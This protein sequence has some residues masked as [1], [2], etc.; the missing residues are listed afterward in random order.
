MIIAKNMMNGAHESNYRTSIG[1]SYYATFLDAREK[2]QIVHG[3]FD[4]ERPGDIHQA[5]I[6]KLKEIGL[7]GLSDKLANLKRNRG[8][9]DYDLN[10]TV[11][12]KLADE[13]YQLA[14]N[15][16]TNMERGV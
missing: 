7:G 4:T 3:R 11:D 14:V 9:A 6:D 2:L 1:R 15:I 8:R 16:R 5:V 10:T 12:V 13:S